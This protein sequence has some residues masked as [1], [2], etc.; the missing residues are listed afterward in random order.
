M[1]PPTKVQSAR[2]GLKGYPE[3][4]FRRGLNSV[5]QN[6]LLLK[7]GECSALV[8]ADLDV[9]GGMGVR[10]TVVERVTGLGAI[11]S[12]YRKGNDIFVGHGTTLSRVDATSFAVTTVTTGLRGSHISMQGI[13]NWLLL[14]DGQYKKK[15]Y[16]PTLAVYEWGVDKPAAAPTVASGLTG[17]IAGVQTNATGMGVVQ[18]GHF[19][20]SSGQNFPALYV[21]AGMTVNNVTTGASM[22]ITSI[23]WFWYSG[24]WLMGTLTGGTRQTWEH[25]DAALVD[26]G[27]LAISSMCRAYFGDH[28]AYIDNAGRNLVALG[29]TTGMIVRNVTRGTEFEITSITTTYAANDTLRST[30][31]PGL[32]DMF[33]H[34]EIASINY[35][36]TDALDGTYSCYYSHV[37]KY[38]D[39]TEHES[40][41]SPVATLLLVS[42]SLLWTLPATVS[43]PQVTH[44]RL[45][46]DKTGTTL[47]QPLDQLRTN[48]ENAALI[49]IGGGFQNVVQRIIL[50]ESTKKVVQDTIQ[51][52]NVI[53]GPFQ[54]TEIAVG[55]TA[56]VDTY[57]DATLELRIPHTNE[58]FYPVVAYKKFIYH[59]KR[60]F[61]ILAPG[62]ANTLWWGQPYQWDSLDAGWDGYN[63]TTFDDD[64]DTTLL[65]AEAYPYIGARSGWKR[66]RGTSPAD[67]AIEKT[68]ATIGPAEDKTCVIAPLGILYPREN[69]LY[70]FNG[71][72]ARLIAPQIKNLMAS[73]NWDSISNAFSL[74]DGRFFRFFYPKDKSQTNNRELIIDTI[75]GEAEFRAAETDLAMSAG[76]FD[77]VTQKTYLGTSDGKL[78]EGVGAS[79]RTLTITTKEFIVGDGFNA[80]SKGQL[81]YDV[82]TKQDA[83]IVTAVYDGVDQT[84]FTIVTDGRVKSSHSLPKG[85]CKRIAFKLSI[86]TDKAPILYEPWFIE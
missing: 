85:I 51:D 2:A 25:G 34:G 14:A 42:G 54:V 13:G 31:A 39:G 75:A 32:M 28:T 20:S 82:D 68:E 15:V 36:V 30:Y 24:D 33:H 35:A 64:T 18:G 72:T 60:I 12:I 84:S 44:L 40:D 61:G 77:R 48:I 4:S 27:G 55:V 69:G 16:I 74:W 29:V 52:A 56:V 37:A 45:Y 66:L 53:V 19:V 41:L 21:T 81:H 57:D 63:S 3:I 86:T 80:E 7:D 59:A 47:S 10:A 70:A 6:G 5:Q 43:D 62:Y 8:N 79:S 49:P 17:A 50:R 9:F 78:L 26:P 83:L 58:N 46:R 11:H 1:P 67:W 73:V 76:Y 23:S 65:D 71:I 38:P 22:T